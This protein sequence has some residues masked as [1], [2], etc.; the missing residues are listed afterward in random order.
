LKTATAF[1]PVWRLLIEERRPAD[2]LPLGV[3]I[4]LHMVGDLKVS[5]SGFDTPRI[6]KS[7]STS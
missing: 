4:H 3:E 5:F 2:S 1:L 7:P 6:V